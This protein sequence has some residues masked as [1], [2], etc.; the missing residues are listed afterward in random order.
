MADIGQ[1][2]AWMRESKSVRRSGWNGKGMHIYL[3]DMFSWAPGGG[4]FAGEKRTY[5]PHLIL[6]NAQGVHQPGW[7]ASTPDLLANDWEIAAHE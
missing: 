1:A 6:F 3:E 2:I 4:V 5:A 7:N